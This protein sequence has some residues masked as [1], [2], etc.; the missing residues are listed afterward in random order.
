MDRVA[1]YTEVRV[2]ERMIVDLHTRITDLKKEP[3]R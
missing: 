3:E 1:L 2:I